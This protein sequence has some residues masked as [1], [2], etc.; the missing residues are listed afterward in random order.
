MCAVSPLGQPRA[1]PATGR[2]REGPAPPSREG[3]RLQTHS[4]TA[5]LRQK[6]GGRQPKGAA[7]RWT[8]VRALPLTA[9]IINFTAESVFLIAPQHLMAAGPDPL[10]SSQPLHEPEPLQLSLGRLLPSEDPAEKP[11]GRAHGR[12]RRVRNPTNPNEPDQGT[13]PVLRDAGTA[14]PGGHS[15]TPIKPSSLLMVSQ[16]NT[17]KQLREQAL[18][19]TG[20]TSFC[21][22]LGLARTIPAKA[23]RAQWGLGGYRGTTRQHTVIYYSR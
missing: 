20:G 14:L 5:L 10:C 16:K 22:R 4:C 8:G 12:G 11:E 15:S 2:D 3:T 17:R 9:N 23:R 21:A 18:T 13:V 1:Q 19:Q 6:A 7:P